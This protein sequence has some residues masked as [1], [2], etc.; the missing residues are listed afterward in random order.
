ME[1]LYWFFAQFSPDAVMP[2]TAEYVSWYLA[3]EKPFFAPPPYVFGVAWGIIY[4]L[5]ALALLWTLWLFFKKRLPVGFVWLFALN[6]ILNFSFSPVLIVT[7]DNTLISLVIVLVLGTLAWL[8]LF[9]WRF[10]KVIFALLLPYLAWVSFATILQLT[11]TA[12]N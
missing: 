9:A 8:T 11:L 7:H 4:P 5:I 10:S 6:L 12:L 1:F 3:L 2:A